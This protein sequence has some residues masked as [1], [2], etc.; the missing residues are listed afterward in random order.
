VLFVLWGREGK[1]WRERKVRLKV[2]RF[3]VGREEGEEQ[4]DVQ[5]EVD[6]IAEEG[7]HDE[8]EYASGKG[9]N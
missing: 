3:F 9:E 6:M 8:R 4:A 2:R 7:T 1:W 5:D